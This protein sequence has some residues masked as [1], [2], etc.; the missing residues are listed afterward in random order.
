MEQTTTGTGNA[1]P[2][3]PGFLKVLCILSFIGTG[4]GLISGLWGWWSNHQL[5][6]GG[7]A[8]M[9]AMNSLPQGG[10]QANDAMNQMAN[11]FG[12]DFAKQATSNLIVGLLNIIVFAGAMMMW[13]LKKSG[14]YIYTLGQIVQIIVPFVVVGGLLG[15]ISGMV[16]SI[17]SIAFIIMYAVNLKHMH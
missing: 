10:E 13:N 12:I 5:A 9:N 2:A 3:R 4:I 6:E 17:F 16:M 7:G 1:A 11:A 8:L 14:F 15:G